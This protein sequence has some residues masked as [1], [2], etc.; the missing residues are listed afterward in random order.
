MIIIKCSYKH[1]ILNIIHYINNVQYFQY[2][3]PI[4]FAVNALAIFHPSPDIPILFN[5]PDKNNIPKN[6]PKRVPNVPNRNAFNIIPVSR[7]IFFKSAPNNNNGVANFNT[8]ICKLIKCIDPSLGSIPIFV[9]IAD[10]NIAVTGPDKLLPILVFFSSFSAA[11]ADVA[12]TAYSAHWLSGRICNDNE[13][14]ASGG[15][16]PDIELS[17]L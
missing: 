16:N 1:Q 5:G 14:S 7:N 3:P 10:I 6:D 4:F 17:N 13:D 8:N 2:V 15:A 9:R 12:M 11:A